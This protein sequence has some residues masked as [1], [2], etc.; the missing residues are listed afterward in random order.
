MTGNGQEVILKFQQWLGGTPGCPGVV[1]KPSRMSGVV[2]R[3]SRISGSGREVILD[4]RVLS[5]GPSD[6]REW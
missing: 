2:K 5:G 6:V 4:V 3:P 1:G